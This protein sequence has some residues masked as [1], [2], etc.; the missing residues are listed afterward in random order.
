[1]LLTVVST[2]IVC[3]SKRDFLNGEEKKRNHT[4]SEEEQKKK[5]MRPV[6]KIKIKI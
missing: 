6:Q 2:K 5:K 4:Q 1:M 3:E